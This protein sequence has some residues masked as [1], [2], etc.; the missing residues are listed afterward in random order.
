M[1]REVMAYQRHIAACNEFAQT[2]PDNLQRTTLFVLATIQQQLETVP[3]ILQSFI[4]IGA[5]S[6]YA[7]GSKKRG[8]RYV[9]KHAKT[10]YCDAMA[11]RGDDDALLKI[12]LRVPGLGLVKSGFVCQLFNNQVGCLDVHN[13]KMYDIAANVIKY[14]KK[15][16]RS[17]SRQAARRRYIEACHTLG[18]SAKLWAKWCAYKASLRPVNW[19]KAGE[20]VSHLHIECLT[21]EYTHSVP[22]LF[23]GTDDRPRYHHEYGSQAA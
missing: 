10:L 2:S 3:D 13:I 19:D 18:G 4:D 15:L 5:E 12:F 14:N 21:G 9:Q 8:I 23:A 7:F 16:K 20:S 17:E 6:M 22:D 11:A 1:V